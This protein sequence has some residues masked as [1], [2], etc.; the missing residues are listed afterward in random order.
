MTTFTIA[1]WN[2][3]S[4]KVRLPQVLD[5]MAQNT[6]DVLCLQ[7]TKM[8][9]D[10]FPAQAFVD[11]G[12]HVSF[13]G[14]KT[15]N[16]VAIVSRLPQTDIQKNLPNFDDAQQRLI[17]ATIN[18]VRI[19]CAYVVNGQSLESEKFE[20]KMN[21]L[22]ALHEYLAFEM[23]EYTQLALLGDFNIAPEDRDV[24]NPEKWVG[25]NLVSPQERGFLQGYLDLGL[26]DS[27][28]LFE[29][30]E[31]SYS[32]WDYRQAGFRRN[33]GLRIDLI[34]LTETLAKNCTS[35]MIDK[36]PRRHEQPSDHT[37]VLATI[38]L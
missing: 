6:V 38:A 26:S 4:L 34:L 27:F 21:W 3:N 24:H 10:V 15:Y 22:A 8:T 13:T 36:E 23:K 31:K 1:T 32:W 28:R 11:A 12:L 25:C 16:G 5:Y 29:Q 9:D 30:A 20:Y 2:V 18:G 19:I 37:P 17:A 14:Q 35:S 7:E 33:A